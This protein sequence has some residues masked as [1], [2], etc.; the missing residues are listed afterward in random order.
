MSILQAS[1]W[2]PVRKGRHWPDATDFLGSN[3]AAFQKLLEVAGY[4]SDN[5]SKLTVM[6]SATIVPL[7][8][9]DPRFHPLIADGY[10]G[11]LLLWIVSAFLHAYGGGEN[12]PMLCVPIV[13][14]KRTHYVLTMGQIT[15]LEGVVL[16]NPL[17]TPSPSKLLLL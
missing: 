1:G 9:E 8:Q 7:Q 13:Y 12:I 4:K 11:R 6:S 17:Q 10:S 14:T 5:M 16:I 3:C 2:P 15:D